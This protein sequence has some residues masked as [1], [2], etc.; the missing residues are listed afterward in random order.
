[1]IETLTKHLNNFENG[2]NIVF[3]VSKLIFLLNTFF[4]YCNQK[5][6]E[7]CV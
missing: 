6:S 2:K 1:M 3:D 7:N 4:D 5:L